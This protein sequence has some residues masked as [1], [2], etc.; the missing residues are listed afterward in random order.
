MVE[1]LLVIFVLVPTWLVNSQV[2]YSCY[3][4]WVSPSTIWKNKKIIMKSVKKCAYLI[5]SAKWAIIA[6]MGN[7]SVRTL[8]HQ[9]I[10]DLE[11]LVAVVAAAYY[12]RCF[13]DELLN[14]LEARIDFPAPFLRSDYILL[15]FHRNYGG[16]EKKL[17]NRFLLNMY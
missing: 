9:V 12:C 1:D 17:V 7:F 4:V 16:T 15:L 10:L 3:C 13:S 11:T 14:T 2:D 5:F 6:N 8:A